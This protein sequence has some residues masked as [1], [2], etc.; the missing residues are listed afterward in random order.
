MLREG[1]N[2][3]SRFCGDLSKATGEVR[4]GIDP[5]KLT[6]A[7]CICS[8]QSYAYNFHIIITCCCAYSK[9]NFMLQ[10]INSNINRF[11]LVIAGIPCP[12]V[13]SLPG[14]RNKTRAA[15]QM[16]NIVSRYRHDLLKTSKPVCDSPIWAGESL[17]QAVPSALGTSEYHWVY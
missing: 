13:R 11:F 6:C 7:W 3:R 16:Q 8:D 12:E 17:W 15:F 4:K 10:C 14:S 9:S 2:L 1:A 5:W